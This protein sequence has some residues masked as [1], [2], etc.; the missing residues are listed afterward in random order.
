MVPIKCVNGTKAISE[1]VKS[2]QA[3]TNAQVFISV[4]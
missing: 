4:R 3:F 1:F 2:K